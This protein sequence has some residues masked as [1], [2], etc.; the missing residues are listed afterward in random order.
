MQCTNCLSKKLTVVLILIGPLDN[1][2]TARTM[3]AKS[4]FSSSREHGAISDDGSIEVFA[5]ELDTKGLVTALIILS[6]V[7]CE[8]EEWMEISGSIKEI[9]D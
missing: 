8:S 1:A 2:G 3:Q 6:S 7:T 5:S 9:E 4:D